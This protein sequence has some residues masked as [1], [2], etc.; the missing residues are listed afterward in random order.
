VWRMVWVI[1]S[2]LANDVEVAGA[3]AL[4]IAVHPHVEKL[5]A[6]PDLE[7]KA[8]VAAGIGGDDGFNDAVQQAIGVPDLGFDELGLIAHL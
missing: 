3:V 7:A 6:F 2:L 4:G 1:K 5:C 8:G